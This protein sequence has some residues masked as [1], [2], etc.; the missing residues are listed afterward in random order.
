M[1]TKRRPIPQGDKKVIALGLGCL[2]GASISLACDWCSTAGRMFWDY[3]YG[4]AGSVRLSSNFEWDHHL[5]LCKGG[6]IG[7][8]NIWPICGACNRRKAG[9]R[10]NDFA[11]LVWPELRDRVPHAE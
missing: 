1:K 4:S 5:P 11:L 7:L 9:M 3:C 10:A 2:P 8:G 6:E